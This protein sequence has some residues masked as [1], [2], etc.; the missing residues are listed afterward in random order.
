MNLFSPKWWFTMFMTTFVTMIFIY[1]IKK[2]S[3]KYNVPFV[4]TISE[5]V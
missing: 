2:T 1:I 4:R 5:E 3:V